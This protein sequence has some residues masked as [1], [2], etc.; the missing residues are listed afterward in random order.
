MAPPD[1][2]K[3]AFFA[4]DQPGVMTVCVNESKTAAGHRSLKLDA[5]PD[6]AGKDPPF[7]FFALA[8]ETANPPASTVPLYEYAEDA[9]DRRAYSTDTTLDLAGFKRRER[10]LCRVWRNPWR[11]D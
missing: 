4:L 6:D 3:I 1:L 7:Q 10:P 5:P 8:A 9:S 11:I 2:D